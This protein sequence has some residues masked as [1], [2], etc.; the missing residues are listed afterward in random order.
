M[1]STR[2][3][4]NEAVTSI[5]TAMSQCL[6]EAWQKGERKLVATTINQG[7]DAMTRRQW[8]DDTAAAL[9]EELRAEFLSY[10]REH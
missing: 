7:F 9:P 6:A 1:L 8:K 10:L 4:R 5:R 3:E 2:E